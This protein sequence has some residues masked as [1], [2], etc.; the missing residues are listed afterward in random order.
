MRR[1]AIRSIIV[2][3]LIDVFTSNVFGTISQVVVLLILSIRHTS[4][5]DAPAASQTIVAGSVV[6]FAVQLVIGALCSLLGGYLAARLARHDERLNGALSSV[7]SVVAGIVVIAI[8]HNPEHFIQHVLIL[9]VKEIFGY[10]GGYLREREVRS[11][12]RRRA[13]ASE[14]TFV[15]RRRVCWPARTF[16]SSYPNA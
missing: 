2:G 9:P 11:K 13:V 16:A 12:S 10:A 14:V 6:F 4:L 1:L 3:G 5:E 8:G 15:A 7:L